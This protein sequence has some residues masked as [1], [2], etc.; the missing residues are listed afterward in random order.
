MTND[1]AL[2]V[3]KMKEF[4]LSIMHSAPVVLA[5][6]GINDPGNLGTIIRTMDWFGLRHLVCSPD[7]VEF[8]N[9][10]TIHS[11]MGSFTRV[12]F[13]Y[14]DLSGFLAAHPGRKVGAQMQGTPVHEWKPA[15]P[16]VL[17]MGSESH[18]I[19]PEVQAQLDDSVTIPRLGQAESLNVGVATGI[20][21]HHLMSST[22]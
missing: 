2:A 6:D 3:V 8:Y 14:A 13:A 15:L 7:T 10:K 18:G 11:T 12:Q 5:L 17:V 22:R 16:T 19:R 9:P 4:D 1:Q 20:L 21:C